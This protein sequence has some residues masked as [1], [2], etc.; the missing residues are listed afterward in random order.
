MPSESDRTQH[1]GDPLTPPAPS[2]WRSL[3]AQ[4]LWGVGLVYF[5]VRYGQDGINAFWWICLA[6][7]FVG[8]IPFIRGL[9]KVW[10]QRA[11]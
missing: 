2:S 5:L 6:G 7:F 3:A 10:V 4:G 11:S 1:A 9:R 8:L